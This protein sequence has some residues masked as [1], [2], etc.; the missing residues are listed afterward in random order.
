M[1]FGED[2]CICNAFF[3]M[4]SYDSF[5]KA[6]TCYQARRALRALKAVVRIQ[7]IFRGCQVRKQAAMTL[8]CMQALVRVQA[9]VRAQCVISSEGQGGQ[10]LINEYHNQNDSTK[11]AEVREVTF[12]FLEDFVCLSVLKI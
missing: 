5:N 7:A 11:Q 9:R 1:H 2:L 10:K 12:T 6:M 4:G 8:R 3:F